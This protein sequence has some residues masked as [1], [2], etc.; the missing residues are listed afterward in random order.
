MKYAFIEAKRLVWP[1]SMLC[2][3]LAVSASG[4]HQ[5]KQRKVGKEPS[6]AGRRGI[7]NDALL[8]H[9]KAIHEQ[10]KGE[11]GWPRVWKELLA[12]GIRVGKERVS[13]LMA[14]HGIGARTKRRIKATT[15]SRHKLPGGRRI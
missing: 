6:K 2:E 8:A 9:V 11:Y 13:Q 3:Q 4:F 10:V 12:R 14:Q 1:I 15:D 5:W 7:S